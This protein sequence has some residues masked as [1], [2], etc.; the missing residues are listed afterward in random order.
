MRDWVETEV[1][2]TLKIPFN[3]GAAALRYE[4]SM[5][6]GLPEFIHRQS[7]A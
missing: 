3:P 5:G 4:H 1:R 7:A 2:A 6:Q